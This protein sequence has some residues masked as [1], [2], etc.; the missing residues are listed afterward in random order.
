M[1][2]RIALSHASSLVAEAI[3]EKLAASSIPTDALVLLD[4]SRRLGKRL[5]FR[6]THLAC[7]DQR[8]YDFSQAALLLLT[9][10]DAALAAQA[11]AEGCFVAGHA[12]AGD[13]P[14]AFADSNR[15]PEVAFNATRLR[16]AGPALSCLLPALV[17]LNNRCQ[18]TQ[19]NTVLLLSAEFRGKAGI[20]ELAT[21]TINL[22]NSREAIPAVFPQQIAFNLLAETADRRFS[23]DLARILGNNSYSFTQQSVNVPVFHGFAAA[24]QLQFGASIGLEDCIACLQGLENVTITNQPA[25]LVSDC[26]QSFSCVISHLEQT[27]DQPSCV[28]FWMLADPL[29]YGLATNYMHVT[30]FLLKSFL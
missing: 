23:A 7:A 6:D 13:L 15:A 28:H 25:S 17:A 2:Q 10:D 26:N 11:E 27:P 14:A 30:E 12:I 24:M 22:L 19:L 16:L 5:G 4:D 18:L 21:Q 20:D 29:R 9:E 1:E 8:D 3:L